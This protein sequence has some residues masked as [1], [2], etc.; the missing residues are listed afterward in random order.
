MNTGEPNLW[1]RCKGAFFRSWPFLILAAVTVLHILEVIE[2]D[3]YAIG[4]LALTFLPILAKT[5]T[6]YFESF[7]LT[8]DGL[9]AKAYA[10]NSGKTSKELEER[11]IAYNS[12]LPES[13]FP[14]SLDS[15]A[16][17]STLWHYQK[18]L[19]G[20]DSLQR[21]GFGVGVGAFDFR[22]FQ[23]GVSPLVEANLVHQ[24]QRGLCYLTN[25][26]VA[27][28]NEHSEILDA[29]GPAFSQFAP[30]PKS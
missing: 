2:I 13:A 12:K 30:V 24:D 6:T 26:G 17:L 23:N 4:L 5:L 21:W 9:E 19:F 29:D 3:G 8:K 22:A 11:S 27:F 20:A 1:T 16:I 10:D 14:Y 15:R 25:E 7:K 28:C 18:K